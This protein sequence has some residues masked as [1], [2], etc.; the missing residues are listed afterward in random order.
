MRNVIYELASKLKRSDF[1]GRGLLNEMYYDPS[2]IILKLR[3]LD[4]VVVDD[5]R[6]YVNDQLDTLQRVK[7]NPWFRN[8]R[9]DDIVLDIGANIGAIT[10]PLAKVAKYVHAVEPLFMKELR[11]NI[12]LNELENVRIHEKAIGHNGSTRVIK[13][14][15]RCKVASCISFHELRKHIPRV[16]YLKIDCEGCEWAID[17]KELIGIRELRIEFHIRRGHG[18]KDNARLAIWEKWL[19]DNGY[20][21]DISYGIQPV[22]CV[23]FSDCVLVN[24]TLEAKHE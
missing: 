23:P 16:D 8:I 5:C 21:Y 13:F 17:P 7:G 15:S 2:T 6:F 22:R 24:A 3:D 4:Y 9:P 19:K 11:R 18:R 1:P 20:N 14:S 10:I 12:Y